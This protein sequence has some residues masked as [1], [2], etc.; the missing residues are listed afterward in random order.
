MKIARFEYDGRVMTGRCEGREL[1][2]IEGDILGG[3][4]SR[5]GEIFLMKEVRLLAPIEPTDIFCIGKNYRSHAQEFDSQVPEK[6]LLF[7]KSRGSLNNPDSPIIL[8][9]C[10]SQ[11]V[12]FE[13]ELAV[14]I[15]RD[16]KNVSRE[17]ALDYVLGYTCAND[18]SARDCQ[19]SDGQWARGK[20]FD[21]FVPLGPWIET[22]LNP[23]DLEITG[24][25]NGQVMQQSRTSQMVFDIPFL[26]SYLS[27]G[28]T[29]R[30]GSVILTG[31]PEGVGFARDPK[32]F[33]KPGDVYEVT[34]EGIGTL[35]NTVQ[36]ESRE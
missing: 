20:S 1:E 16:A 33:L 26:I 21:T 29:L 14:V 34:V 32:V 13:A 4:W 9:A 19:F 24:R 7:I 36:E 27:Q 28:M 23:A 22:Q 30:A 5:T 31:T 3:K 25:L 18:V 2:V 15:A 17:D 6:P 12:D 10:A 11:Q 8:P 35:K